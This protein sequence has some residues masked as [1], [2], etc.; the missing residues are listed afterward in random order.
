VHFRNAERSGLAAILHPVLCL[1]NPLL[2]S[3]DLLDLIL[4]LDKRTFYRVLVRASLISGSV[5][6]LFAGAGKP[7]LPS[8]CRSGLRRYSCSGA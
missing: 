5:F 7:S 2:Q 4:D 8:T 3:I 1:L 6:W